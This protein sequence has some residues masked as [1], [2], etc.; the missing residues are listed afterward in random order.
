MTLYNIKAT[1]SLK[2]MGSI[3]VFRCGRQTEIAC[4]SNIPSIPLFTE[5]S[6]KQVT[7]CEH[8]LST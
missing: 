7:V 6:P 4:V 8:Y 5:T 3:F 1:F 2:V